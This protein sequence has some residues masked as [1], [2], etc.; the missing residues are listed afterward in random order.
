MKI[1][2]SEVKKI[3]DHHKKEKTE[4]GNII[5]PII[6]KYNLPD[7]EILEVCQIGK[8]VYKINSEIKI[9]EKPKPPDPDFIIEYQSK[10]IGLEHTRIFTEDVVNYNKVNSLIKYSEKLYTSKFPNEKLF[11]QI[12]IVDDK[13]EYK[14]TEKRN[15]ATEIVEYIHNLSKG[16]NE[17]KPSFIS[18]VKI[19]IHSQISFSYNEKNWQGPYLTQTRLE[20]EIRKKE[21]KIKNYK[22]SN[23]QISE[24]WLVL[25]IGSL[26]SVSYQFDENENY[27]TKTEFDKVF[28]MTDFDAEIIKINN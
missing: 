5:L 1:E 10:I 6:D 4:L 2:L 20:K 18:K 13:L 7:K 16:I 11:A 9:L 19:S 21:R 24:Y 22:S 26:S 23:T 17:N 27:E 12:S 15:L 14:E 8:F 28:L 25:F 3:I